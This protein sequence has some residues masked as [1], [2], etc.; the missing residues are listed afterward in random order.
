MKKGSKFLALL[1][2]SVF[3]I[4]FLTMFVSAAADTTTQITQNTQTVVE[5]VKA[6]F[7]PIFVT[8][9]GPKEV[10]SSVLIFLLVTL[11]LWAVISFI[12]LFE[13]RTGLGFIVALIISILGTRNLPANFISSI[14]TPSSALVASITVILP[15]I[16]FGWFVIKTVPNK[17]GRIFS[18]IVFGVIFIFLYQYNATQPWKYIYVWAAILCVAVIAFDGV[19]VRIWRKAAI[20][21]RLTNVENSEIE[22]LMG[23]IRRLESALDTAVDDASATDI[24]AKITK[25]ERRINNIN[26][27]VANR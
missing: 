1:L 20:D 3:L 8:L 6:F 9:F 11:V 26:A 12:P 4:S 10:T 21:R 18:W 25:K 17:Y 5:S 2:V 15:F 22:M 16:L 13:N 24:R 14:I 19:I 27:R 23:D 7:K